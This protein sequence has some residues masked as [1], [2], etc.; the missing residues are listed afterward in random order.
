MRH[1]IPVTPCDPKDEARQAVID[2]WTAAFQ[3]GRIVPSKS[4]AQARLMAAAAHDKGFAKQVG[5][6]Q[7]VAKEFNK[8]DA[9]S[10]MLK[11]AAKRGK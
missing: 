3:G 4:K 11:R 8:S 5:I 1:A 2:L 7:T 6:P 9:K 10:G